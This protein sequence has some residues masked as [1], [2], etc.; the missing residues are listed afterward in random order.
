MKHLALRTIEQTDSKV[1]FVI[2]RQSLECTNFCRYGEGN[3][4]RFAGWAILVR[5]HVGISRSER[6]LFIRVPGRGDPTGEDQKGIPIQCDG[7]T[8]SALDTAVAEFNEFM[9]NRNTL[10]REFFSRPIAKGKGSKE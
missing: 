2:S 1:V 5:D 6:V 10:S 4:R 7:S 8:R 9:K 3:E